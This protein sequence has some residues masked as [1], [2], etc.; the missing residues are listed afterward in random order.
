MSS[1]SWRTADTGESITTEYSPRGALPAKMVW[2]EDGKLNTKVE[3]HYRGRGDFG[4]INYCALIDKL[5]GGSGDKT[6]GYLLSCQYR[7]KDKDRA[8]QRA[9]ADGIVFP[10]LVSLRWSGTASDVAKLP[11]NETCDFGGY[12]YDEFEKVSFAF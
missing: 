7:D 8:K 6:K 11:L 4:G 5:N 12:F 2:V 3:Y 9:D 1:L 10:R